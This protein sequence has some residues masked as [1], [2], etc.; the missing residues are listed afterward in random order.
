VFAPYSNTSVAALSTLDQPTAERDVQRD[1][2]RY[3][4]ATNLQQRLLGGEQIAF[5]I[6]RFQIARCAVLECGQGAACLATCKRRRTLRYGLPPASAERS[7][8]LVSRPATHSWC[9][10][11]AGD[12]RE[13]VVRNA[14]SLAGPAAAAGSSS[15]RSR[16]LCTLHESQRL[17]SNY[18][19]QR[20]V[21]TSLGMPPYASVGRPNGF[22]ATPKNRRPRYELGVCGPVSTEDDLYG[23]WQFDG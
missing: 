22:V 2:I 9:A 10:V 4:C 12:S 1:E 19:I 21:L 6:E 13:V 8:T 15:T 20:T 11:T 5:R 14:R 7:R 23:A 16:S 3:L 18:K 17:T